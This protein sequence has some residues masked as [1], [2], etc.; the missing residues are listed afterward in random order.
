MEDIR[1]EDFNARPGYDEATPWLELSANIIAPAGYVYTVDEIPGYEA[2]P[3][4]GI[5]QRCVCFEG[6]PYSATLNPNYDLGGANNAQTD[7]GLGLYQA[8]VYDR[9]PADV[10]FSFW[11]FINNTG[12]QVSAITRG[13]FMYPTFGRAQTWPAS[14]ITGH[15]WM[16]MMEDESWETDGRV[17]T[18]STDTDSFWLDLKDGSMDYSNAYAV[19]SNLGSNEVPDADPN[20]IHFGQWV[21]VICH[22]DTSGAQ[23][24]WHQWLKP[25]GGIKTKTTEWIGGVTAD[26]TWP[27]SADARVGHAG[28]K[29]ADQFQWRFEGPV[30]S[31]G[32]D[33]WMYM[34]DFCMAANEADLPMYSY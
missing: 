1:G 26:F 11:M 4:P 14:P 27:T 29:L 30:G 28:F 9:V 16:W 17:W 8:G 3:M 7:M 18:S 23:G 25:Y 19:S 12:S 15:S 22:Y 6:L 24:E 21:Q 20:R 31:Q 5:S 2:T 34:V 13:K 10:W 32:G 33:C